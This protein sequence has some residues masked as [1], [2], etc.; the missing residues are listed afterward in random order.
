VLRLLYGDL[1][2]SVREYIGMQHDLCTKIGK[3]ELEEGLDKL[4]LRKMYHPNYHP[5][6]SSDE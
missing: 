3:K 1:L 6:T 2:D 4:V 5:L